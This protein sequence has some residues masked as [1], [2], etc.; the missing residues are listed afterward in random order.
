MQHCYLSHYDCTAAYRL[1]I[2]CHSLNSFASLMTFTSS[3]TLPV[4]SGRHLAPR[5]AGQPLGAIKR[6]TCYVN[7]AVQALVHIPAVANLRVQDWRKGCGCKPDSKGCCTLCYFGIRVQSSFGKGPETAAKK[8]LGMLQRLHML[9]GSFTGSIHNFR[10]KAPS[11]NTT[12]VRLGTAAHAAFACAFDACMLKT[13]S[14]T[15]TLPHLCLRWTSPPGCSSW[16]TAVS[17]LGSGC[18]MLACRS[19]TTGRHAMR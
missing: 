17:L 19:S 7:A 3:T 13:E 12:E 10:R 1:L 11:E 5:Q 4:L 9:G 15:Q 14:A 6:A 2:T 16:K 8:P 18:R